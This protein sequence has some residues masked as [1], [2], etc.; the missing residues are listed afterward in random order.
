MNT[1]KVFT[2]EIQNRECNYAL[3]KQKDWMKYYTSRKFEQIEQSTHLKSFLD[4][5]LRGKTGKIFELGCGGSTMLARSALLGWE[6]G[7]IDLYDK[8][9]DL[10]RNYLSL[11]KQDHK[12]LVCG[13]VFSY[14]CSN[15]H[16]KYDLLV[17]FGF[18]EHFKTPQ[19]IIQK[20][21]QIL[22][23]SGVVFSVISNLFAINACLMKLYTPDCWAQHVRYSPQEMDQFH[24]RAGLVPL[25]KA[26]YCGQYSID[27]LTPWNAIEKKIGNQ[28]IFKTTKY[29]SHYAVGKLLG[30]LPKKNLKLLNSSVVGIYANQP[31]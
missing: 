27:S 16:N 24:I 3:N 6:V 17:S 7:G 5:Y 4:D 19:S 21:K 2:H 1:Q 29:F 22:K 15:L 10:I 8:G 28:T 18:L 31:H 11:K 14:D 9:M 12:D 26:L 23:P 30:L 25:K 20:W 13:D